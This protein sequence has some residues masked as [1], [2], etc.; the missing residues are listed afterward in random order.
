VAFLL[1]LNLAMLALARE[2][3]VLA[4]ATLVRLGALI[5][6]P[7]LVAFIWLSYNPVVAAFLDQ[8]GWSADTGGWLQV[9]DATMVAAGTALVITLAAALFNPE[10]VQ[11]SLVWAVVATFLSS[12]EATFPARSLLFLLAAGLA[13]TIAV[14]QTV[15]ALAFR[16]ALTGLPNR[17]ALEE[18]LGRVEGRCVAAMIDVDHFKDFNDRYGHAVGD[19]VLRMVATRLGKIPGGGQAFRYGGEEF[20]VLMQGRT[21]DDAVLVLDALR[22]EIGACRFALRGPDRPKSKPPSPSQRKGKA[23][24]VKLTVSIGVAERRDSSTKANDVLKAADAALY[25]AKNGGR[26][27]VCT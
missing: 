26:N 27:Q 24:I 19:Q 4:P 18:A 17:R 25:R 13:L 22:L 20:T 12:N 21:L 2:R 11:A 23:G 14:V 1:P 6:Q 9:T 7:L 16:D 8:R 10:P 3:G 15:F 5:V